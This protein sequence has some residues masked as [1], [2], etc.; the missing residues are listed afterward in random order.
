MEWLGWGS[1]PL[2]KIIQ[3]GLSEEVTFPLRPTRWEGAGFIDG[4]VLRRRTSQCKCPEVERLGAFQST[5]RGP[6]RAGHRMNRTVVEMRLEEQSPNHG[7]PG[8]PGKEPW[9]TLII[10]G[11][12]GRVLQ[13]VGGGWTVWFVCCKDF[14]GWESGQVSEPWVSCPFRV[15]SYSPQWDFQSTFERELGAKDKGPCL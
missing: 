12:Q 2:E 7:G 13:G 6:A 9:G 4:G 5:A 11:S 10:M 14:L 3:E 8:G 15:E 1:P